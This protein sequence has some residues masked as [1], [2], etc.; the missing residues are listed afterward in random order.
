MGLFTKKCIGVDIGAASIKL[1]EVSKFGK[2]KKL[3]NYA[4]F[5]LPP[6]A[7][8]IK[9]FHGESLLLLSDEVSEILR[10]VFKKIKI[11][12]RKAVLSIPDFSTFFT[13][14]T[15]PPMTESE[16]PQAVE[17]EARHHIPL[18]LSEVT[19]DWQI[20]EKEE[21]LPGVKLKILLVAVP[22][23]VLKNYQRM[24]TLAQLEVKGMEAEVFGL[25]RSTISKEKQH[26][27]LCLVD[28]GWQS[29]TVSIV[30][31]KRLQVS[32]SFDISGIGLTQK[33]SS[34][35]N[36][37][38]MEAEKLKKEYGLDP[39]HENVSKVLLREINSLAAD[40]EKVCQDFYQ[41]EGIRVDDVIIAGGTANLFGLREYLSSRLRKN[42]QTANPFS[43][44]SYPKIL[45]PRLKDLG[46]SFAVALGGAMWGVET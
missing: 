24:A 11:R 4:E 42:V 8:S 32:H 1:V 44:I 25:I 36:I 35:L 13:T 34:A 40:I 9:T 10:A 29:T 28:I 12:E 30:K 43:A 27:P 5:Q 19:F 7:T 22:N 18:P 20:I 41:A 31:R 46:P 37:S 39:H 26:S 45:E 17:F 6:T 33:L 2:K 14:F 15:L 3:E 38:F 16:I 23:N 21:V